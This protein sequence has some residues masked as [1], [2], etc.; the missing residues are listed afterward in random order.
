MEAGI[1]IDD[2]I[3]D[4]A[5]CIT[6]SAIGTSANWTNRQCSDA[7]V[8]TWWWNMHLPHVSSTSRII[9]IPFF[10]VAWT[11]SIRMIRHFSFSGTT[12]ALVWMLSG[13]TIVVRF[14]PFGQVTLAVPIVC[15][16]WTIW[17]IIF[18]FWRHKNKWGF[19]H[20]C[21]SEGDH[22]CA[23]LISTYFHRM[24]GHTGRYVRTITVCTCTFLFGTRRRLSNWNKIC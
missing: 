16:Y 23:N 4:N 8:N 19:Q 10:F 7:A 11:I 20:G 13:C 18:L 12:S 21:R 14:V 2:G 22:R 15:R 5:S 24:R 6:V 1:V 17:L 3:R 9:V